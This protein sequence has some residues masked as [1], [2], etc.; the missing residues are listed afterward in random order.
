VK[1]YT[2]NYDKT[3]IFDKIHHEV[4]Q[5]C[6]KSTLQQ[7]FIDEFDNLDEQLQDKLQKD[8]NHWAPGI[9]IIAIRVTK[10]NI[11]KNLM[12]NYEN[13]ESQKTKL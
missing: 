10:P 6:S 3:W 11:P 7:V 5:F 4:N 13:I 1:N 2:V 12:Q 8:C 9:E